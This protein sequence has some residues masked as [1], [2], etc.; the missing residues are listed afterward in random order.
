MKK[1]LL[2]LLLS[3]CAVVLY[4]QEENKPATPIVQFSGHVRFEAFTDSYESVEGR[5]GDVYLYPR[6]A[7]FDANGV[8]LNKNF[9]YKMF[10]GQSRLRAKIN[11]PEAFGAKINGMF[12]F[13]LLGLST[14]FELTPRIRHLFMNANWGKTQLTLGYTW[15]PV[16]AIECYPTVL[17]MGAAL[18]FNPLSRATQVKVTHKLTDHLIFVGGIF[19]HSDF[20]SSGLYTSQRDAGIP[21][22]HGQLKYIDK[23]F[24]VGIIGGYRVIR[25][26]IETDANVKTTKTL[27]SYDVA[28]FV[29]VVPVNNLTLKAYGIFGQNTSSYVMT[30]GFGATQ[31]PALVDDY[32]YTNVETM[33]AWFEVSYKYNAWRYGVFAGY[34]ENIGTSAD[35]FYSVASYGRGLNIDNIVRVS[36]YITYTSGKVMLGLEYMYNSASYQDLATDSWTVTNTDPTV[37]NNRWQFSTKYTF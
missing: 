6:R 1:H 11:G 26:R 22:I 9:Q 29:K 30:G 21:D 32:D 25:P 13:D 34:S 24:A 37:S 33:A 3:F 12:E 27:G 36:P 28:A 16:F 35:A 14:N 18:P 7:N 17:A 4:A 15:H 23:K 31:N 20:R 10:S 8:D 19:S 5:D 2:I